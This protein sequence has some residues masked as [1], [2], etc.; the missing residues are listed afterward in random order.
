VVE[1]AGS[2][3]K[4]MFHAVLNPVAI[5]QKLSPQAFSKRF[6]YPEGQRLFSV[7]GILSTLRKAVFG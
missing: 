4:P 6:H 7:Y 3:P 2:V 1:A 5:S